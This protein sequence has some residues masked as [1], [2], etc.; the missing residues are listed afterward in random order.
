MTLPRRSIQKWVGWAAQTAAGKLLS[1]DVMR[2]AELP[3]KSDWHGACLPPIR[4]LHSVL[5]SAARAGTVLGMPQAGTSPFVLTEPY[6]PP[7][8]PQC[9]SNF[10][11]VRSKLQPPF[12]CSMRG[13]VTDVQA[14]DVSQ[15]GSEKRLFSIVD[16]AGSWL[17]CC[18]LGR[19]AQTR[20][21]AEGNE[22]VLYFCTGR[23]G[24]GSTPGL[25]YLLK[26]GLIVMLGR[27]FPQWQKRMDIELT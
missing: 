15:Q 5:G 1:L 10:I 19:N 6:T 21:L 4:V 8:H 12:R 3:L 23:A 11:A 14:A 18:A 17:R 13:M 26:D 16:E 25:I 2:V 9:I 27:K 20:A 7:A 24:R 22:V